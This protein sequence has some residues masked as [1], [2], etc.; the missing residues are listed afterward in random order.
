MAE[1]WPLCAYLSKFTKQLCVSEA[2]HR[3]FAS[4]MRC[5]DTHQHVEVRCVLLIT[6]LYV[7]KAVGQVLAK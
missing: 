1:T 2:N 5:C 4:V 6:C 7:E 3:Q